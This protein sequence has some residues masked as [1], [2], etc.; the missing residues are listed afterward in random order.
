MRG[1]ELEIDPEPS[2]EERAAIVAALEQVAALA[3]GPVS[4]WGGP[5]LD[6]EL[7]D[8]DSGA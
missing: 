2:P 7:A 5:E 3:S 4:R 8:L 1:V 6:E